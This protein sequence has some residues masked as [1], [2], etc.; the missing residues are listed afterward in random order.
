MY[1]GI[2]LKGCEYRYK[3]DKSMLKLTSLINLFS[4]LLLKSYLALVESWNN[5]KVLCNTLSNVTEPLAQLNP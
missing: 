2:L 4:I 3:Y 5:V 1:N